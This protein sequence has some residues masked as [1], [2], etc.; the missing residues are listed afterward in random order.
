[1]S[2]T[3]IQLILLIFLSHLFVYNCSP[4][5]YS[6]TGGRLNPL[7]RQSIFQLTA[8]D[9]KDVNR[10]ADD[11][12]TAVKLI[13][14]PRPMG[15]AKQKCSLKQLTMDQTLLDMPCE[16]QCIHIRNRAVSRMN[17]CWSTSDEPELI[18]SYL[19]AR[20]GRRNTGR[21]AI[22]L[23]MSVIGSVALPIVLRNYM[24]YRQTELALD[25]FI[26]E[27]VGK[28]R[29]AEIKG[30]HFSMESMQ[31]F[32]FVED[33]G[34][35]QRVKRMFENKKLHQSWSKHLWPVEGAESTSDDGCSSE[36]SMRPEENTH[37]SFEFRKSPRID[38]D[39]SMLTR[40]CILFKPRNTKSACYGEWFVKA[41]ASCN[42]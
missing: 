23:G 37:Y 29:M 39:E 22:W 13:N 21:R 1:M 36:K 26:S 32:Y 28:D 27:H 8:V 11:Q 18:Y 7:A 2:S 31:A 5:S 17:H 20:E 40:C 10:E 14:S 33:F 24:R 42:I 15:I 30:L 12:I 38:G 35:A 34:K 4:V 41:A 25:R 9:E 19:Q 6:A 3:V 16:H